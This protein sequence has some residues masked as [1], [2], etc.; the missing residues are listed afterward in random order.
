MGPSKL[1]LPIAMLLIGGVLWGFGAVQGPRIGAGW[2]D[3]LE[4]LAGFVMLGGGVWLL[5]RL[6]RLVNKVQ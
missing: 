3:L 1:I 5:G 2:S 4:G 6:T